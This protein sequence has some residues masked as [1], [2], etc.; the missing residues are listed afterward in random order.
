MATRLQD[1]PV[2]ARLKLVEDLWDSIAANP[3]QVPV[4]EAQKRELDK[5]LDK[6]ELDGE[7][8]DP[9]DIVLEKIIRSL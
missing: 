3:N 1:L 4:T 8:G 7:L 5:R 6:F 9:A 2:E